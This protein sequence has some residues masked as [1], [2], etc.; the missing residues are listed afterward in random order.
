MEKLM[1][2]VAIIPAR[3]GSKAIPN[4]NIRSINGHPMIYYAINNAIQ[5]KYI[6]DIIV[7]TDSE[8]VRIIANQM[9][10][11]PSTFIQVTFSL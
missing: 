4:K 3:A 5:S 1:N 9:G 6:T 2:I 7:S 11:M 8:E 10:P